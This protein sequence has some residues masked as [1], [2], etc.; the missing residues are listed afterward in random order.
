MAGI[1]FNDLARLQGAGAV[2]QVLAASLVPFTEGTQASTPTRP[3]PAWGTPQPLVPASVAKPYPLSSLPERL[4]A[5]VVEVADFTQ[6]PLAL[7]AS[8]ALAATSVAIQGL[9]DVQ[10]AEHLKGPVSLYLLTIADSGERKTTCDGFF[11]EPLREYERAQDEAAQPQ[12]R[13]YAAQLESWKAKHAGL[14]EKIRQLAKEGKSTEAQEAGLRELEHEQPQAPRVPRLLYADTTTE[15]LAYGV[16]KTWPS[17][18]VAA[19]EG[20]MVFGAHSMG[21][22]SVMRHLSSLNQFWDGATQAFDRR[23]SES[24][25]VRGGR[26]SVSLQVQD[27]TLRAFLDRG[28]DLPRGTGF[29]ARFLLARPASTQGTRLFKEPPSNWPA[30]SVFNHRLLELLARPLPID[31][32]GALT[33]QVLPLT[34]AAKA[35]WVDYYNR[36]ERMLAPGGELVDVRDVASKSAENAARLAA[37]FQMLEDDTPHAVEEAAMISALELA[38]WYLSEALSYFGLL[39]L[40]SELSRAVELDTW[41]RA[42][43]RREGVQRVVVTHLQQC[44]PRCLRSKAD[45]ERAMPALVETG[46]ARWEAEGRKKWIALNPLLLVETAE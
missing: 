15:A 6:A 18:A 25:T 20:G 26:L 41:L 22:D 2:R 35:H 4:R 30:L 42:Y 43:C 5:A 7:V 31:D 27:A 37:L 40:P 24:F 17:A 28:G 44:G 12:R 46:R 11:M 32:K 33:P 39:S 3:G 29:L 21:K 38:A 36:V 19:A 8:S 16:A 45:I 9:V 34:S 13:D 14:V 1:D 10:R 23:A